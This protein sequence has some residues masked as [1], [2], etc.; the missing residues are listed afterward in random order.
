MIFKTF[1]KTY[2]EFKH[3]FH[4]FSI[5][6]IEKYRLSLKRL[7]AF[8]IAFVLLFWQ[9]QISALR[10]ITLLAGANL[11]F[12][13]SYTTACVLLFETEETS[14]LRVICKSKRESM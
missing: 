10:V 9:E 4:H 2:D 8:V 13:S 11:C 3:Y 6:D 7:F 12:T 1:E 14:N 5:F